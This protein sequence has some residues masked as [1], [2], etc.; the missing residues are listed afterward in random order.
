MQFLT[1]LLKTGIHFCNDLVQSVQP[2]LF[3]LMETAEYWEYI[4]L[5]CFAVF[6]QK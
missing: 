3:S 2:L 5:S 1:Y 6:I 4:L